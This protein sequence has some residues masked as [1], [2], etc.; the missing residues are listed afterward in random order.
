MRTLLTLLLAW[1]LPSTGRHRA[2][3]NSLSPAQRHVCPP[4][5]RRTP[6][7]VPRSPYCV[8]DDI[9]ADGLPAVRP[10]LLWYEQAVGFGA[11]REAA[12]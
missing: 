9:W 6:L 8:H 3:N 10:Y 2:R 11:L 1:L 5:P 12:V 7:P 4:Q